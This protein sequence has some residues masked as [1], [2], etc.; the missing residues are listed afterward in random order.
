[1]LNGMA[2]DIKV[3]NIAE[4][5]T[6]LASDKS[7]DKEEHIRVPMTELPE[8]CLEHAYQCAL[9]A[10]LN[11]SLDSI[12]ESK[13][14]DHDHVR[15]LLRELKR[16]ISGYRAQ[17]V[18]KDKHCPATLIKLSEVVDKLKACKLICVY[19]QEHIR[20]LYRSVR[21]PMQWSL[22]RICNEQNHSATNCAI[23]CLKCNLQRR[24][25]DDEKFL[26]TK[27]LKIVKQD[28][29]DLIDCNRSQRAAL[30][31]SDAGQIDPSQ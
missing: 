1:M 31:E 12:T 2:A 21:D 30:T 6:T 4:P 9:L 16:K 28:H 29:P 26:F 3:L 24:V 5:Q 27:Q 17:D 20:I 8:S 25:R 11:L 19:C 15:L 23:A 13:D 18:K 22:D 14:H 10:R 7:Q